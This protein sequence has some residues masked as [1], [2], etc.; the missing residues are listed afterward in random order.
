MTH[1]ARHTTHVQLKD[2]QN[3]CAEIA[4]DPCS[5]RQS[6]PAP[7]VPFASPSAISG[8]FNSLSKVLFTF[9]SWYLFPIGPK[10]L[11]SLRW[12]LPP[13]LRSSPEERDSMDAGRTRRAADGRRGSHP[14]W[15][16]IPRS[17][18]L[19][20]R[21]QCASRLQFGARGAQIWMLS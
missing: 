15:R 16:P 18:H 5:M 3:A 4:T 7:L 8:T 9:P 1:K 21:W 10:P 14:L 12:K 17:L 19:R 13:D 11:I 20:R 2:C 6:H